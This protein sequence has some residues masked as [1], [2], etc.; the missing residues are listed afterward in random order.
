MHLVKPYPIREL[1][2]KELTKLQTLNSQCKN[3]RTEPKSFAERLKR[4]ARSIEALY[5][6]DVSDKKTIYEEAKGHQWQNA[7]EIDNSNS[8]GIRTY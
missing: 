6:S 7:I 2:D 1:F 8:N 5:L 3:P 4:P